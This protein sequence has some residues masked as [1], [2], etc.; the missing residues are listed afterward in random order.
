MV[1]NNYDTISKWKKYILVGYILLHYAY[2]KI[3]IYSLYFTHYIIDCYMII[4]EHEE[5]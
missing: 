1:K 3:I 4:D 2:Y 5:L